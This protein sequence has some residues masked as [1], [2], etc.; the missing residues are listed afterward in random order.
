[1]WLAAWWGDRPGPPPWLPSDLL[2]DP[3]RVASAARALVAD[4]VAVAE[5]AALDARI[6]DSSVLGDQVAVALDLGSRTAAEVAGVLSGERL[7]RHP[8]RL[9][10]AQLVRRLVADWQLTS[11][12]GNLHEVA[13]HHPLLTGAELAPLVHLVDAATHLAVIE[14]H[15][16]GLS[17]PSLVADLYPSHHAPVPE[18]ISRAQLSCAGGGVVDADA[19]ELFRA[20]AARLLRR[21]DEVFRAGAGADFGGCLRI[22]EVG[23]AV[24]APL[25]AAHGR[26]AV[27]LV[28]AM[29]ADL[30]AHV[31]PLLAD[32]LPGRPPHRQ[33]AV[34]PSPTRTAEAVAA[35]RLGRPVPAGSAPVSAGPAEAPFAHL[36]YE[37]DVLLGADRDD[38][39][40]DLRALWASGPPISVAVATGVDERLH[41]TS[42]EL[43]ALIDEATT[44]LGRR[45]VPSLTALPR[46][47]PLV[48]LA[49]HG[50]RENPQWGHGPEGRYVHGGTSLEECVVPVVVF[51]PAE[52]A[53]R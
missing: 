38:R 49:D 32:A 25:L 7:L 23:Q 18:L 43:A 41:R 42:V 15:L 51:A 35:L 22:W 4:P 3:D 16:A 5:L 21:V 19:V 44:A 9:A 40:A 2:A 26:V 12:V 8:V 17:L 39:T 36:G 28:D 34:V 31:V 10:A 45:V 14:R 53:P 30:A 24:V 37:G 47:V 52:T 50:F 20:G 6:T 29:R 46:A 13:T 27:L 33:W 1:F 11:E 48:V